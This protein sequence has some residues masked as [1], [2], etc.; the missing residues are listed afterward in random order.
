MVETRAARA[1]REDGLQRPRTLPR[2]G[3]R[4]S[5][6]D[7]GQENGQVPE[8]KGSDRVP[9]TELGGGERFPP[10]EVP[11]PPPGDQRTPLG[12]PDPSPENRH[13]IFITIT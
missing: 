9:G 7:P 8:G 2:K 3:D 12:L 10:P 1:G 11:C 5:V 13:L 6:Q 4:S